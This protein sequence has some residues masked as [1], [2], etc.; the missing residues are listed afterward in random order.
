MTQIRGRVSEPWWSILHDPL[1]PVARID[2]PLIGGFQLTPDVPTLCFYVTAWRKVA[3]KD[4]PET[5]STHNNGCVCLLVLD[6]SPVSKSSPAQLAGLGGPG[7]KHYHALYCHPR[8]ALPN[9]RVFVRACRFVVIRSCLDTM[10][11]SASFLL[12]WNISDCARARYLAGAVTRLSS[13]QED[14]RDSLHESARTSI[15]ARRRCC[16]PDPPL[17]PE[18]DSR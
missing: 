11:P 5:S 3:Q 15:A 9:D 14:A 2:E 10:A 7:A 17:L 16:G 18:C 13:S 4:C 6:T 8:T 1:D 12:R